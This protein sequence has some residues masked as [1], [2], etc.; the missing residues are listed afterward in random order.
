V[1]GRPAFKLGEALLTTFFTECTEF[2]EYTEGAH[3]DAPLR[4]QILN[5]L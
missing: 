2:A 5:F 4:V 1:L 3:G